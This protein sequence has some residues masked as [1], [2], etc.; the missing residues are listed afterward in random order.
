[1]EVSLKT[2]LS[3]K[4]HVPLHT[5]TQVKQF[6]CGAARRAIL[7]NNKKVLKVPGIEQKVLDA[8]KVLILVGKSKGKMLEGRLRLLLLLSMTKREYE[9]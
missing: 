9:K 5:Q 8:Q 4:S 6:K 1:M 3:S 2:K 7:Y